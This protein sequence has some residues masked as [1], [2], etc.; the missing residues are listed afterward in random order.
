MAK[1]KC[2]NCGAE[3]EYLDCELGRVM[4]DPKK[5]LAYDD[6]GVRRVVVVNH[7]ET[8][9]G[10]S[11]DPVGGDS[12][13]VAALGSFVLPFGGRYKSKKLDQVPLRALD[14]FLGRDW[15]DRH[16]PVR[17]K[18]KEYLSVPAI[19]AQLEAEIAKEERSDG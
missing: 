11:N 3:V 5:V 9:T 1:T 16:G 6:A 14:W 17:D 13:A 18:I 4:V 12:S 8:C 15:I 19:A 7:Y 2:D 10:K